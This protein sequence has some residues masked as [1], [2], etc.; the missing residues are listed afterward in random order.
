[1][2]DLEDR[3]VESASSKVKDQDQLVL[4][5][6]KTIGEGGSLWLSEE[7]DLCI[8]RKRPPASAQA[9]KVYNFFQV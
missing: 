3:D 1:M 8:H 5:L 6:I 9:S 2:G 7:L 4:K